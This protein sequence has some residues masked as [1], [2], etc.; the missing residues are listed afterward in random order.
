M[1]KILLLSIFIFGLINIYSQTQITLTFTAKDSITQNPVSLDSV[2]VKNLDENCDTLLY[3]PNPVLSLLAGWPAGVG[4]NGANSSEAFFLKQNWPNPFQGHTHLS[5]Y[6]GYKGSLN[7]AIYD[8][9]GV[10]L[11]EYHNGF[12]KGS[13][14]F[15]ISSSVNGVLILVASDDKNWRSMKIISKGQRNENSF[16]QYLELSHNP[17]KSC[18]VTPDNSG[19]I[20]YLGNQMMYT[21]YASEYHENTKFDAPTASTS[22]IFTLTSLNTDVI[23][24]VTTTV[25]TNITQTMATSGGNVTSDGGATVTGRGVCWNTSSNP[26][27][28]N[29]HTTDGNGTGTFV[30]NLTGLTANTLYYVRSYATNSVGTA[31]GNE[32]TFTTLPNLTLPT[33][34]TTPVTNIAQTTATSGGNVTS[35]GGTTVTV[36]GV[37]WNTSPGPTTANS[38]TTDGSGTG[39]FV[40]NLTGLTPN[41]L[42]YVRAYATNS[43]GTSYGNEVTFTTLTLTPPAVTTA[44]VTNITQTTATSGGT[45]ISDGGASVTARGVCWNISSNPTTANSHTTDGSGTGSFVSNLTGLTPNT[46]YYVRSY[47]TNSVGT[48][49]GNELTFTTLSLTVPTVTTAVV[50]NITQTTATSGGTVTSDGGASVTARGVCWN[51]SPGPTTANT[52]TTDGSGTGAFVSN[53]TGLTMNTM[54]YVRSYA[55]NNVG[56]AYGNEVSFTTLGTWICGSPITINHLVSGGVAPVNKTVT[57]GTVTN[58]PGETSKCWITSNLG[59]D[60]QATAVNDTTEASA[61]WH[62]QFNRMQG[63][64]VTNQGT[65][66]PNT[67]WITP[68]NENL[69]WQAANDPCALEM[70]NGW[71]LPTYNE[72]LNVN[73]TGNWTDWNGPW[74]SNLKLHAAGD[75][76]GVD[77]SWINQGIQGRYWSSMQNTT[78]WGW[79]LYFATSTTGLYGAAKQFGFSVRC[80][81]N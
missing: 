61:G 60:H 66:T 67:T 2:Y 44:A 50:T 29:S 33:V 70:G 77:G 42:Y 19:F 58:I 43:I 4:E 53:L 28:A 18:P 49:Y 45:V 63:Y 38:Y 72:W 55:T 34:T 47:A 23:P 10:K 75:L 76:Y 6:R 15:V 71:R 21:G 59:A 37:C 20:F 57:Y 46:L 51:T 3:G 35:D 36:R 12:E 56:T 40:S 14:S 81:K 64:K 9:A 25:V 54:Y 16:I 24:T 32:L 52:H 1:K 7:L 26:T 62:W 8:L 17:E 30:S 27:T 22:Y 48:S 5:I 74:N 11:A 79:C 80:I 69:D 65:R 31:Y 73:T 39:T 41:T 78:V 68:I 13:H